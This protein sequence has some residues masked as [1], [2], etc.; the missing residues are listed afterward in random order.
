[1][2]L[3]RLRGFTSLG[4]VTF[5]AGAALGACMFAL[6]RFPSLRGAHVPDF[7]A[8]FLIAA[9]VYVAAI[10]RLKR[11]HLPLALVWLFAVLFRVLLLTTTP[12]L[13]DDVFRYI[14]DGHLLN[15]GVNPYA[16]PVN[17]TLLDQY[18]IP[19][20]LLV[21]NNW[22]AS[23][24]MPS[25]QLYFAL[26]DRIAPQNPLG[27]QLGALL[28]DLGTGVLVMDMLGRL[29]APRRNVLVYLWNPLII[30]EFAH[31]A[32]I[33]ALTIFS[34][35]AAFWFVLF[36]NQRRHGG[37]KWLYLS[38]GSLAA[39]TLTKIIPVLL[40]PT[41]M[42]RWKWPPLALYLTAV[43]LLGG[44]FG[45]N[46]GWGL[47]GPLDG[48]GLF[49][50]L[51]VYTRYWNFNGGFFHWL[52]VFISGYQTP[53]AVPAE[54]VDETLLV[55]ARAISGAAILLAA[56]I[57]A[58]WYWKLDNPEKLTNIQRDLYLLRVALVPLGAY[59]F[60]TST[61]HPWY[62]AIIMP[63]LPFLLPVHQETSPVTRFLWPWVYFSCAVALSYST[64][65][66]LHNLREYYQIRQLEYIPFYLL[67]IWA[68]WPYMRRFSAAA[69]GKATL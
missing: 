61:V 8:Y 44:I 38:A 12:T 48:S 57:A 60:F 54:A 7:L 37:T 16:H 49:G 22:M 13:S 11:D 59:L 23:P 64:Y 18:A 55:L 17:S 40:V 20:R 47:S 26:I 4:G 52:E 1:M 14:W 25:A 29:G 30:L 43:I 56:V 41:L 45:L 42:R 68:A 10:M 66:D 24:Y 34:L 27:F 19:A 9:C 2:D 58:V 69:I 65:V 15:L 36:A 3:N 62:A 6:T 35:T 32:H 46:A 53:G 51:R 63:F 39:A 31:S 5:L 28:L 50:A 67:L 21:N 33:D